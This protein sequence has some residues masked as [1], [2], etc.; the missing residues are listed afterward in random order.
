MGNNGGFNAVVGNPPF[1]GGARISEQFGRNY[2]SWLTTRFFGCRHQCDLVGYFFRLIY[3]LISDSG[4]MGLVAT[5]TISEGDTRE[6]S[7]L[8]I[9]K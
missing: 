1:L 8:P 2:F 9:V 3:G 6:G 7:L 4:T 5:K